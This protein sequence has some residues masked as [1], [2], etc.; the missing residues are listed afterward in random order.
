MPIVKLEN[1]SKQFGEEQVLKNINLEL[2]KG[3]VVCLIGPSGAG[4]TTL[5]R[6]I[7]ML[8]TFE[9]G[10]IIFDNKF[11]ANS[12][13]DEKEKEK[14]RRKVGMV[15]QEFHLW[16]HRTILENITEPLILVKKLS[17]SE[18]IREAKEWLD[19]VDLLDKANNYPDDLS[20]GQKQRAAIARTLAMEPEIVLLDEITAALDPELVAGVL[21]IIKRL[22]KDG[23]TMLVITHQLRFAREIADRI[24]FLDKGEM[25]EEGDSEV[26][27]EK[28]KKK[29]TQ[30]F[31]DSVL[32][33][34]QEINVYEGYEDFQAYHIGL[35]KRVKTGCTGYVVGA[36]GDRWFE[37]M[38][39]SYKEYEKILKEKNI[40]WKWISYKTDD[41]ERQVQTRL[42]NQ[43]QISLIPK[44]YATPSN[45]NIWEDTIILQTFGEIPAIIEIK[46]KA[47]TSGYL[48][49]FNLLWDIGEKALIK[50]RLR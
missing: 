17:K 29:R 34:K 4:K 7:S 39:N 5:L 1:L 50:K 40:I 23:M 22:A 2:K 47:L 8:E 13:T 32:E 28:P 9:Q 46:N 35:L 44:E 31:L 43:L 14:L 11:E 45:F 25:V 15:F 24:I 30:E 42:G 37:C 21:K 26:I 36:V 10:K 48:N 20:G 41:F 33:K 27:F 18:A 38:D 19:K 12:E 3:E 6:C 49:Y 16:P